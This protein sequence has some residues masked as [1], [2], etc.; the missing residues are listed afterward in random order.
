M[1]IHFNLD[2]LGHRCWACK[3]QERLPGEHS[4]EKRI[5]PW[6][7]RVFLVLRSDGFCEWKNN[8]RKTG[9]IVAPCCPSSWNGEQWLWIILVTLIWCWYL[10]NYIY[11]KGYFNVLDTKSAFKVQIK[12]R[13]TFRILKVATISSCTASCLIFEYS[14]NHENY[15]VIVSG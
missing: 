11:K 4:L 10:C 2:V 6:D 7:G 13:N 14:S 8:G 3:Q 1:P 15:L 12:K 9:N 5:T